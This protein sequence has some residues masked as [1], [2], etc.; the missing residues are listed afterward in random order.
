MTPKMTIKMTPKMTPKNDLQNDTKN[1][2]TKFYP[3]KRPQD[4]AEINI[5]RYMKRVKTEFFFKICPILQTNFKCEYL[6]SC[7]R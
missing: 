6:G 1:Y 4:R 3:S 2:S 5:I 7:K